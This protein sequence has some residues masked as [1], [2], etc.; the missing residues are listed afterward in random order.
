MPGVTAGNRDFL[1]LVQLKLPVAVV[2]VVFNRGCAR[3]RPVPGRAVAQRHGA[4]HAP[5]VTIEMAEGRS[6]RIGVEP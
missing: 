1:S 2:A 5:A 4:R 3:V 6:R